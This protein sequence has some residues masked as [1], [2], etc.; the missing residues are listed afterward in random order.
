MLGD[1]GWF[2]GGLVLLLL[3]G[4]SMVRGVSGLAQA[5]GAA[6]YRAGLYLLAFATSIP[7]LA[8]NAYAMQQGQPALALG[9][10]VGS[11]IVNIGLTLGVAALVAP[12]VVSMRLVAVQVVLLLVAGGAVLFFGLDGTLAR[13]EGGVLLAGF[14]GLLAVMAVRARDEEAAVQ[15]ELA[16]YAQTAPGLAR[17]A[18]RIAIAI[19]VLYLGAMGVVRGAPGLGAAFG[20]GPLLTGLLVV[21]IGTALP[22]V[23]MAVMAA[24]QG[25]GNVVAG[26]VLGASLF[27][28]LLVL[29]GM[30]LVQPVPVP[31]S[32]VGFEVPAAM[33]FALALY[34]L[35]AGDLKLSRREG[36]ILLGLFVLWVAYELFT[37]GS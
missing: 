34:P 31:A 26:H 4:D 23:A 15:A 24:R 25:Q 29:G 12:L 18:V 36:G 32:F 8:V 35:L 3:G 1:L 17:N 7:E 2:L 28:F 27:N 6:P 21:A 5:L 16:D 37:V 30:A 9:N 11:N 13:W 33:A 14:V 19:G 20:F 22:E 10:A